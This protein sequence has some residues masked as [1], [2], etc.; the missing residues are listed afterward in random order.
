MAA[1][2][3]NKAQAKPAETKDPTDTA[4]AGKSSDR[5]T[6]NDKLI[7]VVVVGVLLP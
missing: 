7:L 2:V 1:A 5:K 4:T 6:E 3:D